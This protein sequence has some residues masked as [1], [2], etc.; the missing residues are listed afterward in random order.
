[1]NKILDSRQAQMELMGQASRGINGLLDLL[2][3]EVARGRY[4]QLINKLR[5]ELAKAIKRTN[6]SIDEL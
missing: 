1:M 3:A 6:R 2:K 4:R 5:E